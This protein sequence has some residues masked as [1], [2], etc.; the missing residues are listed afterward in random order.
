[1]VEL[2]ATSSFGVFKA[3]STVKSRIQVAKQGDKGF[4]AIEFVK[5]RQ[6]YEIDKD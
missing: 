4:I 5:C 3:L 1:M 2:V 6:Q